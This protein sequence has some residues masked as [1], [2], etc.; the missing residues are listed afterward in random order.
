MTPSTRRRHGRSRFGTGIRARYTF[1]GRGRPLA[2]ARA[3]IFAQM[4]DDPSEYID[5][6]LSDPKKKR[7]AMRALKKRRAEDAASAAGSTASGDGDAAVAAEP[8]GPATD[9]GTGDQADP[10]A[11]PQIGSGAWNPGTLRASQRKGKPRAAVFGGSLHHGQVP[12]KGN[13]PG[14]ADGHASAASA[15]SGGHL[16]PGPRREEWR[17]GWHI[18]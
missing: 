2:A 16:R 14:A 18:R 7:A 10:Q 6:L 9:T 5:V 13:Q 15:V 1:G 12:P 8:R 4:V 17:D 3:V 11:R